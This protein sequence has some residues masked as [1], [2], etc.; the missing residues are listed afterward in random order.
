MPE[1]GAPRP[2]IPRRAVLTGAG[3]TLALGAF[4]LP[5]VPARTPLPEW[6][7]DLRERWIEVLTARARL[8][9]ESPRIRQHLASMDDAVHTYLD[10]AAEATDGPE[11]FSRYPIDGEN[12]GAL[13]GSATW[14][15]TMARA[16]STP[17]SK[18][19]GD[20]HVRDVILTGVRR[21]LAGGYHE[22]AAAYENW[23]DW[24]IGTPRALADLMCLMR[25]EL[26]DPLLRDAGTAIRY[27]NPDPTYSE[28]MNYPTTA[29]NRV[30][31]IRSALVAAIAEDDTERIK[32]SVRTLPSTWQIVDDLDGFYADGGFIQHLDVPYTGNYGADLLRNLSPMLSLLHG[33]EYDVT[34]REQLW[35]LI[36]ASYLPVMVNGH[37]LDAVRGRA[38]ARI[39]TSGSVAGRGLVGAIAELARTTPRD[40]SEPWMAIIRWWASQNPSV[41]LL[42]G[43]DLPGAVALEPPALGTAA[44]VEG[45]ASTYFASMDRLVHRSDGWTMAVSMCSNRVAA[46]EGSESENS[47]GVLTGNAMRYL[48]IKDD[49][50]P[51]DD[52]FWATLDYSRPPG[53]TNHRIAFEPLVTRGETE[54]VPNNEWTGGLQHGQLSV[55]AMHQTG[56]YEEAPACRRFSVATADVVVE[57]VSDI[58]SEHSVFTTIENRMFP[59]GAPTTLT[60]GG[61]EVHEPSTI[62]EA[63]WAHI[64]GTGGYV[65]PELVTLEAGVTRRVG[66][67][68]RVE[69][70]VEAI[71]RSNRVSRQ[72]ATL[73]LRHESPEASSSWMLLPGADVSETRTISKALATGEH[74]VKVVRNDGTSQIIAL[75]RATRAAAVWVASTFDVADGVRIRCP[76]P[77]LAVSEQTEGGLLLRLTDPT[78]TRRYVQL[79][80]SGSWV[81][82][83]VDAIETD[84]V[85]VRPAGRGTRVT[86]RT[87]GRGGAA[88]SVHLTAG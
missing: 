15:A 56:L 14:L 13:S 54:N 46:F 78:Q 55:T 73:D 42:E 52:Y 51:F 4:L 84:D 64:E 28:L 59:D 22:G 8:D 23:W 62:A 50:A 10:T 58:I 83:D 19:S 34:G 72:W 25:D 53:T 33:T 88:F 44:P 20:G 63:R 66:S 24:E 1:A 5:H 26:P 81:L 31:T 3:A 86:A 49:P 35:D 48:F 9:P 43:G 57:L 36:D 39:S 77:I 29:A 2:T 65:F 17:G 11:I 12:A 85:S 40:R 69:Q 80:V 16:W 41:D 75:N 61:D 79:I 7:L 87:D 38:V 47:S 60:V 82:D 37:V 76:H 32:E 27:F 70:E 67:M 6:P 74:P 30:S 45:P 71:P 68:R 18:F 21:L